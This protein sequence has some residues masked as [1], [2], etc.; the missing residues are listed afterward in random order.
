[1]SRGSDQWDVQEIIQRVV[2]SL[3]L[4]GY[5]VW[6][7]VRTAGPICLAVNRLDISI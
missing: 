2:D 4:A 3:R 7:D 6:F 1:L 5:L